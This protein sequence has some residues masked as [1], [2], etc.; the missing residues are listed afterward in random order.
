[1][2]TPQHLIRQEVIWRITR[3]GETMFRGQGPFFVL[4]LSESTVTFY[5][6]SPWTEPAQHRQRQVICSGPAKLKLHHGVQP[7]S[8]DL[9][10]IHRDPTKP[11]AHIASATLKSHPHRRCAHAGRTFIMSTVWLSTLLLL[12]GTAWSA[13]TLTSPKD[14]APP[15]VLPCA[16]GPPGMACVPGGP[17]L[18]GS[19]DGPKDTQPA[20]SVWVQTF[21]MDIHEVTV[22]AYD[23]CVSA[24]QCEKARTN[25]S[26][27]SRPRQ[28]KVGV[29]WFHAEAYCRAQGKHLPSEAEWEK[30]ARGTDGRL[31][32]WGNEKATCK[33]AVIKSVAGRGCGVKKRGPK[34]A[35]GRT[36]EV[37]TLPPAIH[38]LYDMSGNSWEWVYDWHSE[39]YGTCGPDCEG[40]NPK[41]PCGGALEC[42]GHTR[43]VVR[44][45][46]WYWNALYATTIKR[47]A[48]R[49][50]NKPYHHFGFRCAASAKEAT[51]LAT[52][53]L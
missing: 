24:A 15:D 17:F 45:G 52:E 22:E 12:S 6:D 51:D 14:E 29:N 3:F 18:R 44:G 40:V 42:K 19:H 47:R 35:T 30:A 26:D 48:H 43:R 34:P 16:S 31:Y 27:F 28:P 39:S 53:G 13:K 10:T 33:R 2:Q 46:S 5:R 7:K 38:G 32:P 21:S 50:H 8:N 49:P 37:G 9:G 25:Y 4:G 11:L 1:V 23:A 41:G 36:H 20:A